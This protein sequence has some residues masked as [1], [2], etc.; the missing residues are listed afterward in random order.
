[1]AAGRHDILI[2]K[3]ATFR[4]FLTV[5]DNGVPRDLSTYKA[6]LKAKGDFNRPQVLNGFNLTQVTGGGIVLGSNGTLEATVSATNTAAITEEEGVWTL[7][8]EDTAGVV[9]RLLEGTVKVTDEV[10][11]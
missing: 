1:M 8:L 7:E 3:G 5:R 6:R 2:E 9:T 11:R 10:T 4:L